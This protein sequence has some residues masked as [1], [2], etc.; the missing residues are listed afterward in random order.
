MSG[1]HRVL[2]ELRRH[3]VTVALDDF[4]TGYS[5]LAYLD[6]LPIDVIKIDRSFIAR[7]GDAKA[8]TLI[9]MMV[10][11]ADA[12]GF[13]PVAEGIE[14][15]EQMAAVLGLGC[16]MGQGFYIGRP[17]PPAETYQLIRAGGSLSLAS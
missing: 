9:R 2:T 11:M 17:L 15:A 13:I 5:S 4:G 1:D 14:T 7:V 16:R 12:L 10:D 8:A 3:G 6:R